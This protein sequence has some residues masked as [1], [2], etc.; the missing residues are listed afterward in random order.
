MAVLTAVPP[1]DLETPLSEVTFVVV[2]LET[3]GT[4]A[5]Q[6]RIIEV[7]AAKFRGGQCLG[8]FQTLINPECGVPPF[9][10]VLT[11]IT[12]AMVVPAPTIDEVLPSLL[13]FIGDGVLVGHNLRFDTSFLDAALVDS[14]RP[15]L[16]QH[17]VDTLAVARRLVSDE[18]PNHRLSTL[19]QL[20]RA[21]IPPTHRALDDVLA[22]A[23]VFHGLLERLGSLG[24]TDL[25]DLLALPSTTPALAKLP[26]LAGLP[27]SPG[28]YLLRD[29]GGRVIYVG[30]AANLRAGVRS[31]LP[32]GRRRKLGPLMHETA[33]V[34]HLA[35]QCV[36]EA[37]VHELRLI[38]AHQPRYNRR[39]RRRAPLRRTA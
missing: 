17:R 36:E 9:I 1:A 38:A 29:S 31:H 25:D 4:V 7:G 10:V 27:R 15:A 14:G 35:C 6:S 22:T 32:A 28:V 2:D 39:R 8:T 33:A 12:E 19:A 3:T 30:T 20:F 24:V 23:E 18:V 16:A 34:D 13:E 11:G 5:G 37:A 21:T 26:L